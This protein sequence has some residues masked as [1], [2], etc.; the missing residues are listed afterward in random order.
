MFVGL[1]LIGQWLLLVG[2]FGGLLLIGQDIYWFVVGCWL[3]RMFVGFV[4]D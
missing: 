3:V 4:V 1:L 2:V